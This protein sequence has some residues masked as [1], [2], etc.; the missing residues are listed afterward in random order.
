MVGTDSRDLAE[1]PRSSAFGLTP[2]RVDTR[3]MQAAPLAWQFPG[4]LLGVAE[5]RAKMRPEPR[6]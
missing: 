5:L 2:R 3:E 1:Y 6:H 4:R